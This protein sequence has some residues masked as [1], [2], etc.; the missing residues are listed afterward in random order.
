FSH[1]DVPAQT[2]DGKIDASELRNPRRPRAGRVDHGARAAL[3]GLRAHT[4][5]AAVRA[6]DR[7]DRRIFRERDPGFACARDVTIQHA[8]RIGVAV[9]RAEGAEPNVVGAR[10]IEKGL[11]L[12]SGDATRGDAEAR[13][14]RERTLERGNI[15]LLRDQEE[16]ADLMEVRVGPDLV[17]ESVDGRYRSLRELDV[18]LARELETN[19]AGILARRS[20]PKSIAF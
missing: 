1:E 2:L 18:D 14:H 12:G 20:E 13:P 4:G 6:G 19:A 17:G 5:D 10:V 16:I 15:A 8:G 9:F 7:G 11:G 3:I